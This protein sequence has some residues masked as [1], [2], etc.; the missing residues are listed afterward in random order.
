MSWGDALFSKA[1]GRMSILLP[2]QLYSLLLFASDAP[3]LPA[4]CYSCCCC[5]CSSMCL[6]QRTV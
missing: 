3:A 4:D 5:C 6:D 1:V 2:E